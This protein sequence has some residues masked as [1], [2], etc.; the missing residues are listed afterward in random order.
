MLAIKGYRFSK[1]NPNLEVNQRGVL[2]RVPGDIS[3]MEILMEPGEPVSY[4]DIDRL[5]YEEQ[6]RR[7]DMPLRGISSSK[8]Q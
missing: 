4:Q 3:G 6:E 2:G 8:S 7:K 1:K 5:S